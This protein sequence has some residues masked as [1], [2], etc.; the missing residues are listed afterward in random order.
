MATGGYVSKFNLPSPDWT[1]NPKADEELADY[2]KNSLKKDE[3]STE[4]LQG[5]ASRQTGDV[6]T[7]VYYAQSVGWFPVLIFAVAIIAF[8][9]CYSF[10]SMFFRSQAR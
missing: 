8:V 9:F 2:L 4:V 3:S 5:E 7:Y 1:W 6:Q 10:P